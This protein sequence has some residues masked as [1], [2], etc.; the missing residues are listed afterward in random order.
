MPTRI[1]TEAGQGSRQSWM[2]T[3][4]VPECNLSKGDAD[5]F[6]TELTKYMKEFGR[7]LVH[8]PVK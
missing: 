2:E 5:Q 4:P 3:G 7:V 1:A 6:F 8:I